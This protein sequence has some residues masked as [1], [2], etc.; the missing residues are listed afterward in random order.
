MRRSGWLALPLLAA[1]TAPPSATIREL[2]QPGFEEVL[3]PA[4]RFV[5]AESTSRSGLDAW[6]AGGDAGGEHR[7]L[8]HV[9]PSGLE[10]QVL[11]A[12]GV[13]AWDG[14]PA[15]RRLAVTCYP[16]GEVE[17]W[18]FFRT[19]RLPRPDEPPLLLA[20]AERPDPDG[21]LRLLVRLPRDQVPAGTARLAFPILFEF[22][23]GWIHLAWYHTIVPQPVAV[24]EGEPALPGAPAEPPR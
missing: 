17:G 23:D 14:A 11:L 20:R 16:V 12:V 3:G 13:A 9:V 8:L 18:D 4:A 2:G 6:P 7:A 1:C 21:V 22:V 15:L 5:R 10:D 19:G 24:S